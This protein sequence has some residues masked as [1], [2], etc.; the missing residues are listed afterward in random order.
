MPATLAPIRR[1]QVSVSDDGPSLRGVPCGSGM[2]DVVPLLAPRQRTQLAVLAGRLHLP[3]RMI[4]YREAS[5]AQSVFI[6]ASGV[7]K[8]FRDLPSGK[9]RIVAFL[10]ADDLFGLS[11]G[12][13]YVNTLQ[14]ITPVNLFKI[15]TATLRD[16]LRRDPELEF[17]FLC[18]LTHELRKSQRHTLLVSRRDATG[19]LAMF[20]R[21][22]QQHGHQRNDAIIEFPMS[23]SDAANYLGLS[24]ETV[25]RACRT[26]ERNEI[27]AFPDRH[28][29]RVLDRPRFEKLATHM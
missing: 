24:L 20:L 26:L 19:R 3:A 1:T 16:T 2:V 13:R 8:A 6:V 15:P 21:M 12:H 18:K 29:V 14:T 28:S 10:F 5:A 23:R 22:L 17:Q 4:L 27:V 11:E 25:S 7:L 9:R